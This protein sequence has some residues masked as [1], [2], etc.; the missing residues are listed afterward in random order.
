MDLAIRSQ[1][2][3][4]DDV[5]PAAACIP[6]Q[7]IETGPARLRA[8]DPVRELVHDLVSALAGH[9]A[10]IEEL[11]LRMLV[12]STDPH[13]EGG[14]LHERR[15]FGFGEAFFATYDWMNSSN[16]VVMSRPCAAVEALKLLCKSMGT[17][18]FIL[19]IPNSLT[20]L[21]LLTSPQGGKCICL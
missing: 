17:F 7:A 21:I 20:V 8:G 10:E 15:R 12:K 3:T 1:A 6:H 5:E 16:T 19:F 2:Q 18:R 4:Q 9:L 13:V 11:S 14:A